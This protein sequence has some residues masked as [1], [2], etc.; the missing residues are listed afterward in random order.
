MLKFQLCL[1]GRMINLVV[2]THTGITFYY[3]FPHPIHVSLHYVDDFNI[4]Q[5]QMKINFYNL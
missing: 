5:V 2:G 4:R 3:R 1:I